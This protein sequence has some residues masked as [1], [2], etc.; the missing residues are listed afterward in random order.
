M[1]VA[2]WVAVAVLALVVLSFIKTHRD[3]SS[4][5]N[6]FDL[7]LENGR[8]S[9]MACAFWATFGVLSWIMVKVLKAG[10][11]SVEYFGAYGALFVAP[12]IA[13]MFSSPPPAGTTTTVTSKVVETKA[14]EGK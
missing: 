1:E 11:M 9:K 10:D 2:D 3:P 14:E 4:S 12:I 8:L 6:I 13:K 5:I 7:V